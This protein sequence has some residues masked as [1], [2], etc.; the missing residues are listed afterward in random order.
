MKFKTEQVLLINIEQKMLPFP[1]TNWKG[2]ISP[3]KF[4]NIFQP[5]ESAAAE[6]PGILQ[7]L[8]DDDNNTSNGK[9]GDIKVI[10]IDSFTRLTEKLDNYLRRRAI[11]GYEKWDKYAEYIRN[12]FNVTSQYKNK[13]VIFTGLEDRNY[14]IDG[15]PSR[16]AKV[17][18]ND[19]KGAVESYFPIVL[20]AYF[21]KSAAS[22]SEK[23]RFLTSADGECQAKTPFGMFSEEEIFFPNDMSLVLDKVRDY[24]GAIDVPSGDTSVSIFLAGQSGYGKTY[25]LRNL[26]IDEEPEEPREKENE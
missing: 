2:V 6:K 11:K 7:Y 8:L 4:E 5:V 1:H 9:V 16:M 18:G 17:K 12:I 15:M 24:Y 23:Y 21:D 26:V 20:W 22:Q 19:L 13:Y 14:D 25:S 3:A 10:I